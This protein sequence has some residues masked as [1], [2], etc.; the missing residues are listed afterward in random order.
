MR[1]RNKS[2]IEKFSKNLYIRIH[3]VAVA[4]G[5]KTKS[6]KPVLLHLAG[7]AL[8]PPA[9]DDPVEKR[10]Q[11]GRN[12]V[13]KTS[14]K[15][16]NPACMHSLAVGTAIA[17]HPQTISETLKVSENISMSPKTTRM[18]FRIRADFLPGPGIVFTLLNQSL[19]I[20]F[21]MEYQWIA[22]LG[23]LVGTYLLGGPSGHP[24]SI[25]RM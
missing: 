7:K 18:T 10:K 9:V 19:Y 24:V 8:Q 13:M 3:A 2:L 22:F 14:I 1:H 11:N 20:Y 21:K 12:R 15:L 25:N 5:L 23:W 16:L 6:L 17:L 4:G